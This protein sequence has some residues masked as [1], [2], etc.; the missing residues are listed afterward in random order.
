MMKKQLMLAAAAL[1]ATACIAG[2]GSSD[3]AGAAKENATFIVGMEPTFPPFEF[4]END[5]YVG[6]DLDLA[7]ALCDKMG[8]KMEVKSMGFDALIPALKSGQ[9][10][11]IASGMDATEE[12]AKQVAFTTPYFFD[13]YSVVVRKDNTTINGFDDL[14]GKVVGA[15][16][17]TK[18]VDIA[19]EHG[20]AT[21]KQYDANSQGWM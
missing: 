21:V 2:C 9:I 5:K 15:Q 4:T 11:M 17:G 13:G 16:V 19:T 7:Q 20:A 8:V 12:R 14:K 1:T 10:D 6:F 3:N 18:P